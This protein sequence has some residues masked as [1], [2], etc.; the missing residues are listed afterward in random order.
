MN[1]YVL[2]ARSLITDSRLVLGTLL[3]FA[4]FSV[5][6]LSWGIVTPSIMLLAI[7]LIGMGYTSRRLFESERRRLVPGMNEACAGVA[8]AA[9]VVFWLISCGLI[10]ANVGFVPEMIGGCLLCLAFAM[11]I[12]TLDGLAAIALFPAYA[13]P[14]LVLTSQETTK[15]IGEA[16]Q[17]L[18]PIIHGGVGLLL[19]VIGIAIVTLYCFVTTSKTSPLIYKSG[20]NT[21]AKAVAWVAAIVVLIVAVQLS[22]SP[23]VEH[24]SAAAWAQS[25]GQTG[26]HML[27]AYGI[28]VLLF[29]FWRILL[30]TFFPRRLK[31]SRV[32]PILFSQVEHNYWKMLLWSIPVV[33]LV[34]FG[35]TRLFSGWKTDESINARMGFMM[36]IVP[37]MTSSMLLY[38]L[39]R[40]FERFWIMG[41]S[42]QRDQTSKV[43]LI[44]VV[45]QCLFI[46][47][48][49]LTCVTT[50]SMS[51]SPGFVPAFTAGVLCLGMGAI[52]FWFLSRWH[53]F[54]LEHILLTVCVLAA[55]AGAATILAI[56]GTDQIL[57]WIAE[58][59][60]VGAAPCVGAILLTT[61]L[62]FLAIWDASR[63]MGNSS[64]LLECNNGISDFISH[65]TANG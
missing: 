5:M 60:G 2:T 36:M 44:L 40:I 34:S 11:W 46:N 42:E 23:I 64:R 47:V 6:F 37:F 54:W 15:Q 65:A 1:R 21:N 41:A 48:A 3:V 39:P 43:I 49:A 19:G 13:L 10:V 24:R 55:G 61:V 7:M 51:T 18:P 45:A 58:V 17:S 31:L 56:S 4:A 26:F 50:I 14:V 8:V 28:C 52:M 62:W 33:F 53:P 27:I 29:L 63:R 20:K 59:A 22:V 35:S 57:R 25:V 16:Y 9:L 12:G 38:G 32:G 30:W